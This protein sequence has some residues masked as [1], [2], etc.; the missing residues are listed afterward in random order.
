M[1]RRIAAFDFD[2]T[3]TRSDTV[4]PFLVRVCGRAK[5]A[6]TLAQIAPSA[7]RARLST[8]TGALH[9]RD[10]TKAA[11]LRQLFR[12]E[13]PTRVASQGAAY[14]H[15]LI[16][17]LRPAMVRQLDWHRLAGHELIIVSASL[18]AYLAPFAHEQGLHH[19]IGVELEVGTDGLLTGAMVGPNV[20][21]EEKAV[22]LRAWL[23]GQEPD[24]LWAYGNSSG[25]RE[26]LAMATHPVWVASGRSGRPPS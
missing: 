22:R 19:V 4:L 8:A 11:V 23:D 13:D 5:V 2:G 7:G 20:R 24:A 21:G 12:G 10:A 18:M 9:H 6:R 14:A 17:R 26:L 3:L 1:G 25:D 15:T 16:D